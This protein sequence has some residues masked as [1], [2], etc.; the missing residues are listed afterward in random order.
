MNLIQKPH[1]FLKIYQT[2][3]Q[4]TKFKHKQQ[5]KEVKYRDLIWTRGINMNIRHGSYT[6][7]RVEIYKKPPASLNKISRIRATPYRDLIWTRW[8]RYEHTQRSILGGGGRRKEE[9]GGRRKEEEGGERRAPNKAGPRRP[10]LLNGIKWE[11]IGQGLL[12]HYVDFIMK[13]NRPHQYLKM[14]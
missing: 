6:G 7:K 9:G 11:C 3:K 4:M 5:F 8:T 12:G 10:P 14:Y 1:K 2:N 13:W